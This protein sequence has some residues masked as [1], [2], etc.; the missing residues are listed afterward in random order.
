M[1]STSGSTANQRPAAPKRTVLLIDDHPVTRL[2]I[3][4]LIRQ[5]E[6]LAVCGETGSAAAAA[7]LVASHVPDIAVVDLAHGTMGGIELVRALKTQRP[8]L[9][10]L[11]LSMQDEDIFAERA[12]RAGASGFIM[13]RQPVADIL[14]AIRCVLK[15][16]PYLSEAMKGKML[17]R[18]VKGSAGEPTFSIDTLTDRELEVF[19]LMGNGFQTGQIAERLHLSSKTVDS[20]REHLK[21]KL[22]LAS[23]GDLV[24]HAIQWARG[25][26]DCAAGGPVTRFP[27]PQAPPSPERAGAR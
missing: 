15:G 18:L 6:D 1:K 16:E 20:H 27:Q 13:K 9:L 14:A 21:R 24:R 11:V 10:V 7:E 26:A 17:S 19:R 25:E 12:F 5:E 4:A 22:G 2:G 23:G 3:S 8:Q